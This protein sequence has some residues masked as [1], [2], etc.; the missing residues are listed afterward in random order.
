MKKRNK[1]GET[2]IEIPYSK[3]HIKDE[4]KYDLQEE[5]E[6]KKSEKKRDWKET[7]KKIKD[8]EVNKSHKSENELTKDR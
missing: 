7:N 8:K 3:N 2:E 5:V 4:R 6:R 1:K